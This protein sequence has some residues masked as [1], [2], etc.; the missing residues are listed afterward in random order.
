MMFCVLI[1]IKLEQ[2]IPPLFFIV[3]MHLYEEVS[4]FTGGKGW[5]KRMR[6]E[7][8]VS[9]GHSFKWKRENLTEL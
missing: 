4:E 6:E 1:A 9:A 5:G 3:F 2:I 7:K 8:T